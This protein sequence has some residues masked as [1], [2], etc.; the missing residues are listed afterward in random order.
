[1]TRR[2]CRA[3][4]ARE[5]GSRV[6]AGEDVVMDE[7]DDEREVVIYFDQFTDGADRMVVP[8]S[9]VTA[10]MSA[11]LV[12]DMRGRD[13]TERLDRV[14]ADLAAG[15]VSARAL[16]EDDYLKISKTVG[17]SDG[18]EA[19]GCWGW[20]P[21][22]PS[23]IVAGIIVAL[24]ESNVLLFL[25]VALGGVILGYVAMIGLYIAYDWVDVRWLR[26][27]RSEDAGALILLITGPAVALLVAFLV[28]SLA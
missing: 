25:P 13:E 24:I 27:G 19:I 9:D 5:P 17:G 16:T 3:Y 2:A 23:S 22:V 7:R 18:A 6:P 28:L 11:A 8:A 14:R 10:L 4:L 26:L 15:R 20:V 1:M 12:E 21:T